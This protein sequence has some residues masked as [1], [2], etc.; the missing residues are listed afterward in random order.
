MLDAP[1]EKTMSHRTIPGPAG[2]NFDNI[3]E[4]RYSNNQ[5]CDNFIPNTASNHAPESGGNKHTT[6]FLSSSW[7]SMKKALFSEDD[8]TKSDI[9]PIV[10]QISQRVTI[11]TT[12]AMVVEGLC[13]LKINRIVVYISSITATANGDR[14]V[15]LQ[16][17][18]GMIFG[19][20]AAHHMKVLESI[21]MVPYVGSTALLEQVSIFIETKPQVGRLL[22]LHSK[23]FI[24][25]WRS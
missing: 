18:T 19:F 6:L 8:E 24:Q 12:I 21:G 22:N 3:N 5:G 25:V 2:K 11:P 10:D 13:D 7:Q 23:C 4:E 14:R 9:F 1:H 17:P 16:D 20:V 15:C